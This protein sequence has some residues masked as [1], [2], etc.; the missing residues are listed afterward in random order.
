MS[1]F[2]EDVYTDH[3]CFGT[4]IAVILML[5]IAFGI[6]CL[7][8]WLAMALWNGCAVPAVTVINEVGFWQMWGIT[9]LC[10][11][12]FKNVYSSSKKKE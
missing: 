11:I 9:L 8:T 3:G 10:N 2:F 7:E 1:N 5:A 6:L 4:I 12:L